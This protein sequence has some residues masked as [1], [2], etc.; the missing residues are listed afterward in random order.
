MLVRGS[1]AINAIS[2]SLFLSLSFSLSPFRSANRQV[3]PYDASITMTELALDNSFIRGDM[4]HMKDV[5]TI[6]AINIPHPKDLGV[7]NPGQPSGPFPRLILLRNEAAPC[8]LC[9]LCELSA[10]T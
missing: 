8:E 3:K 9:W 7:P 6:R 10:I 4:V 1:A 2:L 5:W